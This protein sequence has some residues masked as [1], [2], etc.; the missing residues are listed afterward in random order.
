[1]TND[2]YMV[3]IASLFPLVAIL[4][5][6]QT[7][8]YQ[9]LVIRGILGA[10]AA[11]VYAM[12]GAADVALTEA[13]VGT[14]LSIT[15]YAIAVR[16]SMTLRIGI[17][18]QQLDQQLREQLDQQPGEQPGGLTCVPANELASKP[19]NESANESADELANE[20]A[21]KLASSKPTGDPIGN[22][23][24]ELT[25][26]QA[27]T[28]V[29]TP[30]TDTFQAIEQAFSKHHVRVEVLSYTEPTEL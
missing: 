22:P 26:Q 24:D 17:V 16:S 13:L 28:V 10:I 8:P 6:L 9:A 27:S 23:I 25:S 30:S 21:N 3:A 29:C 5:V 14:M 20:L 7:N 1:M 18:Q 11:L 4:L 12:L 2:V 15:L 19:A